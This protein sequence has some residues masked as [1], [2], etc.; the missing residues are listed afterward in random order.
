M[1][2]TCNANAQDKVYENVYPQYSFLSNW[3]FGGAVSYTWQFAHGGVADLRKGTNIGLRFFAEKEMNYMWSSRFVFDA[4]GLIEAKKDVAPGYEGFDDTKKYD[5]Y[6]KLGADFKF[7]HVNAKRGYDPDRKWSTYIFAGTGLSLVRHDVDLGYVGMYV[8]LGYGVGYKF[9]EHHSIFAEIYGDIVSDVPNPFSFFRKTNG[10]LNGLK[11]LHDMTGFVS[12]GYMYNA[13]PIQADLDMIAQRAMLTQ[14]NFD[15]K[16]KEITGLRNDIQTLK[17]RNNEL[18][19]QIKE[20]EENQNYGNSNSR[21]GKTIV[22]GGNNNNGGTVTVYDNGVADSLQR[23]IDNYE[24]NKYNFYALPFSI[25]Y[26]ID[27]YTVSEDQMKKID[28]I[29]QVMKDNKDIKLDVIGYCDYSGSDAYNQKLS[30]KRAENVK[31]LLV[32]KGVSEDRLTTNGK[33][34]TISFGDIKNAVNRRVSFYRTNN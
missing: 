8:N 11:A 9:A 5:R 32:R 24:T 33:G 31:K 10:K 12:V 6:M 26:E 19:N 7:D 28:A 30:E 23:I 14:E 27:E 22:R 25:L 18:L 13:G 15:A 3:S 16:D 2:L 1:M 17:N 20:L 4:A 29:A 21:G 34:K